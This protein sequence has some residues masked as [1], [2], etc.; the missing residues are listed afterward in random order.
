[1]IRR[2]A[3]GRVSFGQLDFVIQALIVVSLISFAVETI[4]DLPAGWR[5]VLEKFETFTVAVFSVEYLLRFAFA[6]PR[7]G[8]FKSFFGI[9]DLLSILP[10]FLAAGV[11]LR[12]LR[13]FRSRLLD[14]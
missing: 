11:D 1:M 7:I 14:A 5:N 9:I 6:R 10:F 12:S 3:R 4:P 8:Y 2:N 13:A